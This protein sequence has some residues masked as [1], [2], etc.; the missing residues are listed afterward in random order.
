[1]RKFHDYQVTLHD[2]TKRSKVMK[3]KRC[4]SPSA[5]CRVATYMERI[6]NSLSS[7]RATM[8]YQLDAD[9]RPI[10]TH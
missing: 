2:T 10:Y 8:A 7:F 3:V 6:N 4:V 1:M 9:G 5:A